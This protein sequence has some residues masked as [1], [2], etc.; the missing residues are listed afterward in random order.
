MSFTISPLGEGDRKVCF[1]SVW[2]S[3]LFRFLFN[4]TKEDAPMD[5]D[6]SFVKVSDSSPVVWTDSCC[7]RFFMEL[8]KDEVWC[9]Y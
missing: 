8:I 1:L 4:L 6:R 3:K 9:K 2:N 5:S 7:G